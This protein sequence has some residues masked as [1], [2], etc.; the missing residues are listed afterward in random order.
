M[1]LNYYGIPV[2]QP[3]I[4]AR[5]FGRL[6]DQGASDQIISEALNGWA[7]LPNGMRRTIRSIYSPGAPPPQLLIAELAH[8]NPILLTFAT[9][10]YSG[11]AVVITGAGFIPTPR[12]PEVVSVIIRDPWPSPQNIASDGRNVSSGPQLSQFMGAARSYFL[13][14][15]Q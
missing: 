3:Q 12:G 10:P 6:I 1:I 7:I 9:G 15:V 8:G 2:T 11:H 14:S 13:V 4:V 5:V